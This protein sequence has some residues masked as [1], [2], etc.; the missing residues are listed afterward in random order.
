MPNCQF[1]TDPAV[2]NMLKPN[3]V[4]LYLCMS[5]AV[6]MT[7][8]LMKQGLTVRI[9]D[10]DHDWRFSLVDGKLVQEDLGG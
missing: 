10:P 8:I 9:I 7:H 1:C 3:A 5:H 4:R 6:R 2:I